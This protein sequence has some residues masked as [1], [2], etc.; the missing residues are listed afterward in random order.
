MR[1]ISTLTSHKG[2]VPYTTFDYSLQPNGEYVSKLV[3]HF[4]NIELKSS[5]FSTDNTDGFVDYTIHIVPNL[6]PQGTAICNTA[7]IY[8]SYQNGSFGEP[9]NTNTVCSKVGGT[10]NVLSTSELRSG[11]KLVVTPN[12][13]RNFIQIENKG[14]ELYDVQIV[15][16]LGQLNHRVTVSAFNDATLD[17]KNLPAGVYFIYADGVFVQKVIVAK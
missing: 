2:S 17:V 3:T 10:L 1:G 14:S 16:T 8:F 6:I 7:K 5:K 13:I 12:P 11:I 4:D 9:L 15:N